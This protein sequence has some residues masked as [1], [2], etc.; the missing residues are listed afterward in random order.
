MGIVTGL[1]AVLGTLVAV[2]VWRRRHTG[3]EREMSE[4]PLKG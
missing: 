4:L 3:R 2:V 1:L